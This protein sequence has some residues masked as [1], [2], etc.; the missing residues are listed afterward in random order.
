MPDYSSNWT[1]WSSAIQVGDKGLND[2]DHPPEG[3]LNKELLI[4]TNISIQHLV[5]HRFFQI[6]QYIA[7]NSVI[8]LHTV[9]W[10]TFFLTQFKWSNSYI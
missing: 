9:K 3:G 1:P 10:S 6:L 2:A 5:A 8:C 4:N 7:N